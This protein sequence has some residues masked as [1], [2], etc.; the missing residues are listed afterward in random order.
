M[1]VVIRYPN[2][3]E[4]ARIAET[5]FRADTR[6]T[7]AHADFADPTANRAVIITYGRIA[8]EA[9]DAADKLRAQ[10]IPCGVILLETLK[11]Y[12]VVA[13]RVA[14]LLPKSPAA[15]VFLEEGIRNGGAGMLTFDMLRKR[16]EKLMRNKN[17]DIAAI[18]DNFVIPTQNESIRRTAGIT[19][20]DVLRKTV[21]LLA[22]LA[23]ESRTNP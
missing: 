21:H 20:N 19:A 5:F 4:D 13:D 15:I 14:G 23:P 10:G 6:E 8:T 11:P 3:S 16:H 1:P 2:M 7:I 22:G 17:T 9:L 12:E 18:D